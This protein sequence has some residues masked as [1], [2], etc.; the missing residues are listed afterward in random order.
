MADA[1]ALAERLLQEA[2]DLSSRVREGVPVLRTAGGGPPRLTD[3]VDE[4][5]EQIRNLELEIKRTAREV[6]DVAVD[7]D[8][9]I[10][11]SD[12]DAVVKKVRA[13]SLVERRLTQE[14]SNLEREASSHGTHSILRW[15][16][17]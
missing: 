5:R 4:L 7:T 10:S 15:P 2:T 11:A 16:A 14:L 17:A 12:E 3:G 6:N 1:L 9:P 13:L 8:T